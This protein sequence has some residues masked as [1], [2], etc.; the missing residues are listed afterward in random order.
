MM[1]NL[2]MSSIEKD[3]R[4][5][6]Q[7]WEDSSFRPDFLKIYPTLVTE[8]S[9][10]EKLW[11]DGI[12][13]TY[14]EDELIDL[15]AYAKSLLPEYVRLQR[16]QRDIPARLI[17]A[18][19]RHSNFRQLAKKRLTDGGGECRCIRCREVG[20]API[21]GE[22]PAISTIEYEC[23][24][25][26]EFFIQAGTRSSLVGF[27]RVRFPSSVFREELEGSALMRELHVYGLAVAIGEEAEG[28]EWQHRN[29]GKQLLEKA[30]GIAASAGYEKMAV[31]SGIGVRPYYHRLGYERTGP[32][33]IKKLD[34]M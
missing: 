2:P 28:G 3:R 21:R 20:R 25:G 9:G 29:Y 11:R 1:P 34:R 23:C 17:L 31:M 7:L 14:N 12:Y 4:M 16:M 30:E 26:K 5:F 13:K 10:I 24:G 15:V 19:S 27:S 32:Y 33:M 8:G 22:I 6:E 18:G